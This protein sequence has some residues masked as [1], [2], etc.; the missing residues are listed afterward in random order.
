MKIASICVNQHGYL[1]LPTHLKA[2]FQRTGPAT[3][4]QEILSC[5]LSHLQHLAPSRANHD[6][7]HT[8]RN[9]LEHQRKGDWK[10]VGDM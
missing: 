3:T 7:F 5:S 8:V 1:W 10:L 9:A 4:I 6:T 2:S